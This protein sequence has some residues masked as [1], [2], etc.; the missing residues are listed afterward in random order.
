MKIRPYLTYN[1][2]CGKAIELYKRAFKTE[3]LQLMRFADL[4]SNPESPISEEI[5]NMILQA[6]M[7]LGDGFIRMSDCRGEAVVI[8]AAPLTWNKR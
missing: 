2:N 3:I 7:K 4:P 5:K 8:T 6:T 1:G